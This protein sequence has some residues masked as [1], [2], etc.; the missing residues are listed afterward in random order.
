[1]TQLHQGLMINVRAEPPGQVVVLRGA[2][3]WTT[4]EDA[5]RVLETACRAQNEG[6]PMMILD[7]SALQFCD[8]AGVSCLVR[9]WRRID[10]AGGTLVL[11]GLH[12]KPEELLHR[13]GVLGRALDAYPTL[14]LAQ[15]ALAR[16]V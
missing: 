16:Q 6:G 5:E 8:S 3:D 10:D 13:T 15:Q 4:S 12:G 11:A 2:L 1:M 7:L 9:M 14:E